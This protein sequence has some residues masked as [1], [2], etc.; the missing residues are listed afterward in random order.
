VSDILESEGKARYSDRVTIVKGIVVR[1]VMDA[2][3]ARSQLV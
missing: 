1:Y 2:L 3:S